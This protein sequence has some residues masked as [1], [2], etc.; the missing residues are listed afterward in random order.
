MSRTTA[1][2]AFDAQLPPGTVVYIAADWQTAKGQT[3]PA[4]RPVRTT[5]DGGSMLMIA[6]PAKLAA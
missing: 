3:S 4:C 5:I 1:S 2:I 6:R